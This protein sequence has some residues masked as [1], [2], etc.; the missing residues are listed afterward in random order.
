M[1][2]A[3]AII[4]IGM[5]LVRLSALVNL[6]LGLARLVCSACLLHWSTIGEEGVVVFRGLARLYRPVQLWVQVTRFLGDQQSHFRINN[7]EKD[8]YLLEMR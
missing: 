1:D 6:L 3:P 4:A 2:G 5:V 7:A 8:R